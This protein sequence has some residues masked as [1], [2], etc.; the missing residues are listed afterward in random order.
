MR[1]IN[2]LIVFLLSILSVNVDNGIYTRSYC[3][4]DGNSL[5]VL[6]SKNEHEVRSVAS[7]SKIMTAL[8]SIESD[9]LFE[10]IVVDEVINSIEG[11]SL[12]LEIGNEITIIDLIY[13]L[14]LRSGNDAA[15]LLASNLSS[16]ID[17]FVLLMNN[18]AREIG[19][20]NTT[21][22][23]PSGL[24]IFDEGNLS[25]TYDMSILMAYCLNNPLFR[26]ISSTKY[27]K[28]PL[29]GQW[30]NKNKLLFDYEYCIGGKT[31]YTKKARRTL[32]TASEKEKQLLVCC[33]FDCGNDFSFHKRVSAHIY[34]NH[35]Y[36]VLLN[37]GKNIINDY[38]IYSDRLI[39]K[40]FEKGNIKTISFVYY[41]N[42]DSNIFYGYALINNETK[43]D[44]VSIEGVYVINSI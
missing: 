43:V 37:K 21:F 30:K 44:L 11:S 32:V 35:Y 31:G 23:N 34:N 25:T 40:R 20:K 42:I 27:Y 22:H 24:D 33:T 41:I 7:I 36:F 17:D 18:K 19:M 14:I 28:T 38:V 3:L 9:R 4:I 5:E 12:Y 2:C 10:V 15:V 13:G 39:G 29:K 6:S 26:E 16:S 1:L 8:I